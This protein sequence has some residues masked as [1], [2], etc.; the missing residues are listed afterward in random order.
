MNYLELGYTELFTREREGGRKLGK[1]SQSELRAIL[2][3]AFIGADLKVRAGQSGY[4]DGT[5]YFIG[6]SGEKYKF[7]IGDADNY[8]KWDGAQLDIKGILE[9]SSIFNNQ[10]YAVADLPIVPTS[11]GPNSPSAVE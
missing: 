11:E 1:V 10:A 2:P 4:A 7:S 9:L 6:K 8:M 3:E 5:G